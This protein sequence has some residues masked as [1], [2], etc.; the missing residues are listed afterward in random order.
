MCWQVRGRQSKCIEMITGISLYL[1]DEHVCEENLLMSSKLL[2]R[3]QAKSWQHF[4]RCGTVYQGLIKVANSRPKFGKYFYGTHAWSMALNLYL[5]WLLLLC[6]LYVVV[7]YT[8]LWPSL[9]D[10]PHRNSA[11]VCGTGKACHRHHIVTRRVPAH[12]L[13][14][15]QNLTHSAFCTLFIPNTYTKNSSQLH[16]TH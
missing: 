10:K 8:Y 1:N 15:T 5:L 13:Q 12:S 6:V 14:H 11:Q 7:L 4:C 3:Q 16:P 9:G 2:V